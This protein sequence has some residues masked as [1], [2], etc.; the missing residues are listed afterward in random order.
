MMQEANLVCAEKPTLVSLIC[1]TEP[2]TKKVEKR[3]TKK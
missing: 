3:K 2:K 1:H